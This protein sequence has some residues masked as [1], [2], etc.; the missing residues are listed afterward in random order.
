MSKYKRTLDG[1]KALA[2]RKFLNKNE[3]VS[4]ENMKKQEREDIYNRSKGLLFTTAKDKKNRITVK[5]DLSPEEILEFKK[6][7]K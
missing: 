7:F 6:K 1:E 2:L 3:R 5:R 4:E